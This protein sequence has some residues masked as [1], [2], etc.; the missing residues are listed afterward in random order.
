MAASTT[1]KNAILDALFNGTAFSVSA[2]NLKCSLHTADPGTDGSNEVTG[3]SYA[4]QVIGS[5][6]SA[7]SGGA[8][9]NDTEISFSDMP[10]VTVTYVGLWNTT[11]F[12]AG[13]ALVASKTTNAGDTF[14]FNV[15][16]FDANVP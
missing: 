8:I 1:F 7:A 4:Q 3:G 13:Y 16:D 15:G 5:S 10:A 12:L 11:T 2:A 6:F 14:K 9:T